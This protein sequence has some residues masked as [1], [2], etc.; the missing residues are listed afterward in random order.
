V[1]G[2]RATYSFSSYTVVMLV[3]EHVARFCISAFR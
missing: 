1:K 2:K 3:Q